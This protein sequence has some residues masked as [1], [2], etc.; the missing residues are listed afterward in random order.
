MSRSFKRATEKRLRELLERDLGELD[1]IAIFIDGKY[2][3]DTNIVIALGVTTE[4]EKVP[5]GFIETG[6]ENGQVCRDFIQGLESRGLK[7]DNEI[8]FVI[9]GSKGLASGI[10]S[11]LGDKAIIQRCQWHK[12]ENIVSYLPKKH[13]SAFRNKLQAAYEAPS[14]TE[15][16]RRLKKIRS[17]LMLI[18]ESAAQSLD[19]GLEETLTLHRLGVFTQLGRSF[20]TT[21]CIENINRQIEAY[22]KRVCRWHNSNQRRRWIASALLELAPRLNKVAGHK[23]LMLL[24]ER[25]KNVTNEQRNVA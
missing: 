18:N 4:G 8:L 15:A 11:T 9:D 17:E 1:I 12:R 13:Q 24:R 5:L 21:N 22:L 20:K 25:M 10:K 19:E 14:Y 16:K 3:G 23:S 6:T 7:T 2:L